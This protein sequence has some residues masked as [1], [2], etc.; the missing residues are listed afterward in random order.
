[1]IGPVLLIVGAVLTT[2]RTAF[3]SNGSHVKRGVV[4]F[5]AL[6]IVLFVLNLIWP[7][8]ETPVFMGG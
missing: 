6:F 2:Q 8:G 1:M 5:A 3:F 7:Y 4:V